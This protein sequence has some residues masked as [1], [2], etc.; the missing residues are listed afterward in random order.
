MAF[1]RDICERPAK[2]NG[3]NYFQATPCR[4]KHQKQLI[5][6]SCMCTSN[7][8]MS[9]K[10]ETFVCYI[11]H[12]H[13]KQHSAVS[14]KTT[15][16]FDCYIMHVHFKQH[17]AVENSKHFIFI[18]CMSNSNN[19]VSWKTSKTFD[20]YIVHVHFKQHCVVEHNSNIWLLYHA[21]ALQTSPCHGKQQKHFI[22][23]SRMCSSNNTES[24]K[25]TE[26]SDCYIMHV[27]FKQHRVVENNRIIWLLYHA[28]ALQTIP[29]R[30]KQ[31]N[32]L[33]VISCMCT[34]NNSVSWKTAEIFINIL[35][36]SPF[37]LKWMLLFFWMRLFFFWNHF[38]S[39]WQHSE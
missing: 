33:I 16:T 38:L 7:N 15:G 21:Y 3:T 9:W 6:I 23:I 18:S 8:I 12:V 39:R 26:I 22:V 34:S 31:Q 29:C 5:V 35:Y 2:Q 4:R 11:M 25:T 27:L 10:I 13:F 20:R 30:G 14:W 28:C 24:W 17:H 36:T 19:K 37:L 1:R 32:H